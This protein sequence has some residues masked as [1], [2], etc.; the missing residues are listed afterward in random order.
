MTVLPVPV[1]AT[2]RFRCRSR[3]RA[4]SIC[5]RSRSW[6]DPSGL[7]RDQNRLP[8][9]RPRPAL[10][11][12]SG[13]LSP[14]RGLSS[15]FRKAGCPGTDQRAVSTFAPPRLAGWLRVRR[16]VLVG[17][18]PHFTACSRSP[19]AFR[20]TTITQPQTTITQPKTNPITAKRS[21]T[22][23]MLMGPRIV[24]DAPILEGHRPGAGSARL[25]TVRWCL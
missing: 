25:G 23:P 6:L 8:A 20:T 2:R 9:N 17:A 15:T 18:S 16:R 19:L 12:E 5:S 1:A 24:A 11:R 22:A 10:V 21:P 3:V 4:S 14:G 7:Q 13:R